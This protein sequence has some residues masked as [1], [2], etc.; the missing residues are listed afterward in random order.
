MI[1]S[2]EKT[3]KEYKMI[4]KGDKIVIGLSGG[5]D[6]VCLLN[7][8]LE[9]KGKHE[10]KL[11]AVHVNHMLR[12]A[13]AD[14][15][16]LFVEKVCK[17]IDVPFFLFKKDVRKYAK[18]KG[19]SEEAAGREIRYNAFNE[20]LKKVGGNKIAIAHN[21]ND[22]AETILLNILRGAGTAGLVGIKPVNGCIIRP[23]IRT[24]RDEILDYL[25][26]KDLEYVIDATNKEDVYR[27]NRIRL[28][29]I[30][31]IEEN[32]DIDIVE[33]LYRTSQIVLD[34]EDYLNEEC[35]K[36]FKKISIFNK[37]SVML[38]ICEI[39]KLHDSLKKRLIRMAYKVIRG[40][41]NEL[42]FKHVEDVLNLMDK[43]T[44][45]KIDL[46]FEIEVIKSYN[47]LIFRKKTFNEKNSPIEVQLNIPG[48]TDGGCLGTYK[49][50]IIDR[51]SV[52][53]LNLGKYHKL[54]DMDLLDGDIT[55]RY[56]R[57]G[58]YISPL[59]MKGTKT[60]KEYFIDEKIPREM[61]DK[62]PLLTIGSSVLWIVGYRMSDKYKVNEGTK[63]IL[64]IQYIKRNKEEI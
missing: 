30:P 21:K 16:A 57:I 23:L 25:T 17:G 29:L 28:K 50:E 33:N 2:F 51:E 61:R 13:D 5:P 43:Q 1:D 22:V 31:F 44:S 36:I 38:D 62:I 56:R 12:G 37:E 52:E 35:E 20:V 14:S 48:I 46:P 32:F 40:D 9:L 47:N 45:S 10:L 6:S 53:K 7:L 55:V 3:I 18:E 15:D 34:D 59:N 42:T 4:E 11:Y 60:L 54:F 24:T 39:K 8:L 49:A 19:L 27:R 58:D 64:S 41:T 26:S 63:K